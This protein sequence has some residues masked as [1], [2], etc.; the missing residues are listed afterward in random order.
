M[1]KT[2]FEISDMWY[3]IGMSSDNEANFQGFHA[4]NQLNI[5]DEA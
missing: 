5:A 2:K 1:F 3:M 4:L